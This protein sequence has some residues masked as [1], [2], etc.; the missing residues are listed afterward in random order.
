MRD[1]ADITVS[2]TERFVG[3]GTCICIL[4]GYAKKMIAMIANF[5]QNRRRKNKQKGKVISSAKCLYQIPPFDSHF[6]PQ[7]HNKYVRAREKM[8]GEEKTKH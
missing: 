8:K 3:T 2:G 6:E 4:Q 1:G 5:I 7:V